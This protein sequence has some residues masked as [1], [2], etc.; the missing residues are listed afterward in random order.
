MSDISDIYVEHN[1]M[2]DESVKGQAYIHAFGCLFCS[3]IS[4]YFAINWYLAYAEEEKKP[5]I[6]VFDVEGFIVWIFI[7]FLALVTLIISILSFADYWAKTIVS[8][9]GV[10][11]KYPYPFIRETLIPWEAFQT[12]SICTKSTK[13]RVYFYPRVYVCM[14]K[15]G[16]EKDVRGNWKIEHPFHFTRVIRLWYTPELVCFLQEKCGITVK[17]QRN[18]L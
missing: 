6:L 8:K 12:I 1:R 10:L 9:D 17:D 2:G 3:L 16:E 13:E 14:V 7:I 11:V 4:S 15:Y 18:D 5:L